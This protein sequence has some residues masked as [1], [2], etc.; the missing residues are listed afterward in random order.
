M[1]LLIS[2]KL[3]CSILHACGCFLDCVVMRPGMFSEISGSCE[4][5]THF[6]VIVAPGCYHKSVMLGI[7]W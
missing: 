7:A 1:L 6:G 5:G 2:N 4:V 3:G